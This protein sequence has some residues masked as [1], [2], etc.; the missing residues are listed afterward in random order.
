MTSSPVDPDETKLDAED[1][2]VAEPS[3]GPSEGEKPWWDNP[4]MPWKGKPGRADLGCMGAITG[5]GIWGLVQL[6]LRPVLLAMNPY[7]LAAVGGGSIAMATIGALAR[8]NGG[9]WWILGLIVGTLSVI[10]F[11]W[12]FWWAGKLWGDGLI[13]YLLQGRGAGARKRADRAVRLTHKY[14]A[15][16]L[17]ITYIPFLPIPGPIVYGAL[18]A[19]GTSLRKFLTL[20]ILFALVSRG[21]YMFLGYQ[22]GQPAVDAL[23]EFGK[24][25]WYVSIALIVIVLGSVF[26]RNGRK[27][28]ASGQ[29]G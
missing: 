16:A 1:G 19:A 23:Q 22:I 7:A 17:G 27:Q 9:W 13:D 21:I 3:D 24:Y 4:A 15:L 26:W 2:S 29:Q 14:E 10:K 18:G 6:P 25:S 28:Q 5:M 12:I 20:D 8:V 11:D